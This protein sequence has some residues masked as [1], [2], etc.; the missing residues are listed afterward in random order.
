M[1][2]NTELIIA[3][4]AIV[5]EHLNLDERILKSGMKGLTSMTELK[6]SIFDLSHTIHHTLRYMS[7]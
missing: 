2:K 6:Y 1:E 3:D 7:M 5:A 4:D